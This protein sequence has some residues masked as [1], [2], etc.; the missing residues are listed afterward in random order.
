[1]H[2]PFTDGFH[3]PTCNG[4]WTKRQ[5]RQPHRG[6]VCAQWARKISS[7]GTALVVRPSSILRATEEE[8][9]S[10]L[11]AR[12]VVAVDCLQ[13]ILKPRAWIGVQLPQLLWGVQAGSM[14]EEEKH[15][16]ICLVSSKKCWVIPWQLLGS[17]C[18]HLPN[19]S[20]LAKQG[21]EYELLLC[22]YLFISPYS[23]WLGMWTTGPPYFNA[24]VAFSW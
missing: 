19:H 4:I 6:H 9:Q 21:A 12:S 3:H 1:M 20:H 2:E 7:A 23:H 18:T 17:S 5:G 22:L 10:E 24:Q 13:S 16:R 14:G 15:R 11:W 8:I